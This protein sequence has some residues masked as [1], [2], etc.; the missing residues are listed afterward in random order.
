MELT[1]DLHIHS[2]FSRATSRDL[3][4]GQLY[5]WAQR[6][7]IGIV[8][9]GDFT[10]PGWR[11]ELHEQLQPIAAEPG[12][13]ELRPELRESLDR[14]IPRAC[15]AP[16][17]FVLTAETSHIYKKDGALRKVHN[18]VL[19][20]E[21]DLVE[22]L[23]TRL[24]ALGC[25]LTADG[26]PIFG[27]PC[28]DFLELILQ[29][30]AQSEVAGRACL[31]PAHIW[32][33]HF[34]LFGSQ[35]GFDRIEDCFGDLT[36]H[37]FA[38][39]TGLSSDPAMNWRLSQL[40]RFTLISNSDAHSAQKLGREMNLLAIQPSFDHLRYALEHCPADQF[41][42]TVEFFPEEGKYHLDGHRACQAR[43]T[44][45]ERAARS[46]RC[47]GCNQ[48][49]TIGVL[50]RVEDLADRSEA[51]VAAGAKPSRARPFTSLV[52]LPEIVAEVLGVGVAADSA[53]R[54]YF[55]L[56]DQLGNDMFILRHA[57]A[58]ELRR[59]GG[60]LLAEAIRRVRA[61]E[62]QIAA[63]YDGEYGRIRIFEPSER[64]SPRRG[65]DEQMALFA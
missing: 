56:L 6:K 62:L 64:S 35:S 55:K 58:A 11:A 13:F 15:R 41:L 61:G 4:L 37:I 20:P 65:R 14:E 28:R 10:H 36:S 26:R 31:I 49:V 50:S 46:G 45:Q 39:E 54:L 40:D 53:Q 38:L 5:Q 32:T 43:L 48:P 2:R 59:A 12:F 34:S 60:E 42:G 27:L 1:C 33:P 23:C 24:A 18:L 25:N 51:E 52:P 63:G 22:R 8:G 30:D 7:G 19:A 17:R 21:L 44:P 16:V 9:T 47:P 29:V 3:N 57:D